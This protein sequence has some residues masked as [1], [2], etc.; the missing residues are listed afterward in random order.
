MIQ[1]VS[2]NEEQNV[3]CIAHAIPSMCMGTVSSKEHYESKQLDDYKSKLVGYAINTGIDY[4]TTTSPVIQMMMHNA[5]HTKGDNNMKKLTNTINATQVTDVVEVLQ[6]NKRFKVIVSKALV[7]KIAAEKDA[8]AAVKKAKRDKIVAAK[9]IVEKARKAAAD[10]K[11]AVLAI[12]RAK[13]S[14]AIKTVATLEEALKQDALYPLFDHS[15]KKVVS[16][17]HAISIETTGLSAKAT[18]AINVLDKDIVFDVIADNATITEEHNTNKSNIE[19]ANKAKAELVLKITSLKKS[20][21]H[22]KY[23]DR[24]IV[25]EKSITAIEKRISRFTKISEVL[26]SRNTAIELYSRNFKEMGE[27]RVLNKLSDKIAKTK[28]G[29]YIQSISLKEKITTDSRSPVQMSD[30]SCDYDIHTWFDCPAVE[31]RNEAI[32]EEEHDVL[33]RKKNNKVNPYSAK[34]KTSSHFVKMSLKQS[35]LASSIREYGIFKRDNEAGMMSYY[36][37]EKNHVS[38][39]NFFKELRLDNTQT[40]FN[41]ESKKMNETVFYSQDVVHY[42]NMGGSPSTEKHKDSYFY[43]SNVINIDK[44]MN[45]ITFG[46][47]GIYKDRLGVNASIMD[48]AKAMSRSCQMFPKMNQLADINSYY[49]FFGTIADDFFDGENFAS[50]D[51]CQKAIYKATG[52]YLSKKALEGNAMQQRPFTSKDGTNYIETETFEMLAVHLNNGEEIIELDF[53]DVTPYFNEQLQAAQRGEDSIFSGKVVKIGKGSAEYL[54]DLNV[55]KSAI[56]FSL[57]SG[58]NIMKVMKCSET[59]INRTLLA[60][61]VATG[62]Q[63]RIDKLQAFLDKKAE[64][65]FYEKFNCILNK[66]QERYTFNRVP[67]IESIKETSFYELLMENSSSKYIMQ[68]QKEKKKIAKRIIKGINSD[69]NNFSIKVEGFSACISTGLEVAF[70]YESLLTDKEIYCSEI[71]NI[72]QQR[73]NNAISYDEALNMIMDVVLVKY[74]TMGIYEIQNA[75]FITL[76]TMIDRINKRIEDE[77]LKEKFINYYTNLKPSIIILSASERQKAKLAGFDNDT[78]KMCVITEPEIVEIFKDFK[79]ICVRINP[80]TNKSKAKLAYGVEQSGKLQN[81]KLNDKNGWD[82][83]PATNMIL[84]AMFLMNHTGEYKAVLKEKG[85]KVKEGTN[86]VYN[87]LPLEQV[88]LKDG[89]IGYDVVVTGT[90][91]K[92][93][94]KEL[95][96][97]VWSDSNIKAFLNDLNYIGRYYQESIIDFDKKFHDLSKLTKFVGIDRF[98]FSSLISYELVLVQYEEEANLNPCDVEVVLRSEL[99][100]DKIFIEDVLGDMIFKFA[101]KLLKGITFLNKEIEE[102]TYANKKAEEIVSRIGD[103][104]GI[105][106]IANLIVNAKAMYNDICNMNRNAIE[107]L[108]TN[109]ISEDD[110]D[111]DGQIRNEFIQHCEDLSNMLRI[112]KVKYNVTDELLGAVIM[113]NHFMSMKG[114]QKVWNNNTN[115]SFLYNVC[116]EEVYKFMLSIEELTDNKYCGYKVVNQIHPIVEGS[117]AYF[118]KGKSLFCEINSDYSGELEFKTIN[119]VVYAVD[120][121]ANFINV[122]AVNDTVLLKITDTYITKNKALLK[123]Q[124][125]EEFKINSIGVSRDKMN[126]IQDSNGVITKFD[127][128]GNRTIKG[129]ATLLETFNSIIKCS[130]EDDREKEVLFARFRIEDVFALL[131]KD[132]VKENDKVGI[133]IVSKMIEEEISFEDIVSMDESFAMSDE[134]YSE[135]IDSYETI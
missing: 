75:V 54:F 68:S 12:R 44:Y 123:S 34:Y 69:L 65:V 82:V 19:I 86:K 21:S 119:G 51:P 28:G 115:G 108:I 84:K 32:S 83:G 22:T 8:K 43:N 48:T 77:K 29:I 56:D 30:V 61:V 127:V 40:K 114:G 26:T 99:S 106:E 45:K 97:C 131:N 121:I 16:N 87:S 59:N 118:L 96:N 135:M 100:D 133:S 116:F 134:E 94:I 66:K 58:H 129:Q 109:N 52:E 126:S 105:D 120:L 14:A 112:L 27:D 93:C 17:V 20:L 64:E 92:D 98:E 23:E 130:G 53:A 128:S 35:D 80:D 89:S 1:T 78:D 63:W 57:T 4:L 24:K 73:A 5:L 2:G 46:A 41:S 71:N 6:N 103:S 33:L 37:L 42:K 72:I 81:K 10:R 38:G 90:S 15:N 104:I 85:S 117:K 31:Y 47:Y 13:R 74:P 11:M 79:D 70:G 60:K 125:N 25:L 91:Y 101:S 50:V 102:R 76:E 9:A 95:Q 110:E 111:L 67:S 124:V 18:Q 55:F 107:E 88:T 7:T 39:Q 49:M 3:N 62:D 132:V 122:P 113:Y 36:F